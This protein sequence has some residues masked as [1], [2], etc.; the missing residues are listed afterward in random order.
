MLYKKQSLA[1]ALTLAV[2]AL[3]GCTH[4][5]NQRFAEFSEQ[6][7]SIQSID[8]I[9]DVIVES[10]TDGP[11]IGI[12]HEKNKTALDIAQSIVVSGLKHRGYQP[13]VVSSGYGLL[14][15]NTEGVAYKVTKERKETGESVDQ[16]LKTRPDSIWRKQENRDYL[17][18][19]TPHA[20]KK[21]TPKNKATSKNDTEAD[22]SFFDQF[23]TKTISFD[24]PYIKPIP[25]DIKNLPAETLAFVRVKVI[26][27]DK[28]KE[29]SSNMAKSLLMTALS[30]GKNTYAVH[31][32]YPDT[33]D[34][35]LLDKKTNEVLWHNSV[36]M[37][38]SQM[39]KYNMLQLLKP[40]PGSNGKT[41]S[42]IHSFGG[43][44]SEPLDTPPDH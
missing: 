21:N 18:S 33:A 14:F 25:A 44:S 9:L 8:V 7:K 4:T 24:D 10:E 13:K 39:V 43:G 40:L 41:R 36:P 28:W 16:W 29:F 38:D 26:D 20:R 32:I 3:S 15:E 5:S 42:A 6:A 31:S 19:I 12:N 11:I 2:S 22:L 30:R 23:Q 17:A 35:V 1:L 27:I 37:A 34:F